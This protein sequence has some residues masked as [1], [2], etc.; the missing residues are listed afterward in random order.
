MKDVDVANLTLTVEAGVRLVDIQARLA[1]EDDRCYLPL[2]DLTSESD[3]MICSDRSH[4]GCF[5]PVDPPFGNT[6]TIGGII[7]SNSSGPRRL[8]YNILDDAIILNRTRVR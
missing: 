4:S 5:L 7:A 3:E 1:T 8:L 2:E 6:A